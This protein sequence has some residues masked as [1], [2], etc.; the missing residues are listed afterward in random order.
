MEIMLKTIPARPICCASISLPTATGRVA[1]EAGSETL[2]PS[3]RSTKVTLRVQEKGK[4]ARK[5]LAPADGVSLIHAPCP[6]ITCAGLFNSDKRTI[7]SSE[8][9]KVSVRVGG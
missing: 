6:G 4:R 8:A 1:K 3:Y 2:Q 5:A 9:G 7:A